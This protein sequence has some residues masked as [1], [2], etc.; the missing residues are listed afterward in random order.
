MKSVPTLLSSPFHLAEVPVLTDIL[1]EEDS[2]GVFPGIDIDNQQK[3][4]LILR[5]QE[6]VLEALRPWVAQLVQQELA[7]KAS[8]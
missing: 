3:Q 8:R 4:A 1:F 7:K 6:T 2:M 5:L